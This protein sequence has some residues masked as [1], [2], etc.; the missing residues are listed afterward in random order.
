[1]SYACWGCGPT[2]G[3]P[4]AERLFQDVRDSFVRIWAPLG[5]L[6]RNALPGRAHAIA[7]GPSVAVLRDRQTLYE[8]STA[9][10]LTDRQLH[11][12]LRT[13]DLL[14]R[15]RERDAYRGALRPAVQEEVQRLQEAYRTVVGLC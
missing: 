2:T 5:E 4:A 15:G 12:S 6:E 13:R 9:G 10:S 8:A 1:M 7:F 3:Y 14:E 11:S